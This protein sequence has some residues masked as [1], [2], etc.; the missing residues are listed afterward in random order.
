[1]PERSG[2]RIGWDIGGAH[3]KACRV[4]DG[5]PVDVVQWPC[6]LWEGLD[7]L[8]AVL[9]R[10]RDRWPQGWAIGTTHVATMTGEMV[11]LFPDREQGVR[12]LAAHLAERLGPTLRLYAGDAGWIA[13]QAAGAH[14]RA[15]ASANWR[16]TASWLAPRCGD[17]VL[18]DIGSTTTDLIPM[19]DGRVVA[20]GRNDAERLASGELVYQ[21]VVRTPLCAL[22]PRVPF[23]GDEVNVMNEWFATT[24]D[25]YRLTGE[26][27]AAHDQH[28]AADRGAKDA[29]ATR[30]RLARMVGRDAADAPA[31]QWLELAHVWRSRQLAE[32]GGQLERVVAHAGLDARCTLVGAGCGAFL[33]AALAARTGRPYRRL[34]EVTAAARNDTLARWIDVAAPAVAVALLAPPVEG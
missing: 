32:I 26:L 2:S 34:A 24:A 28:P 11:D 12:R 22:G 17:A 23:G 31:S 29:A 20:R 5:V 1:M 21:G 15:I 25:V 18:V 33:A 19:R 3:V 30:Q 9:D 7:R 27:D 6:A 16:A 14:W 13:P 8:D 4:E 10:A